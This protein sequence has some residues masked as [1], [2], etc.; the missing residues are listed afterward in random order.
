M[1]TRREQQKKKLN[2]RDSLLSRFFSWRHRHWGFAFVLSLL[3]L[4]AYQPAWKGK[5]IWDDDA[6]MMRP[7]LRSLEGLKRIWGQPGATQQ[8]YPVLFSAFWAE[9]KLWGDR[10]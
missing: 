8:Y 3:T 2:R 6:H 9:H 10:P 4:F 5:P 7:E 1:A